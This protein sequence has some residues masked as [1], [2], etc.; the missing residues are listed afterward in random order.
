MVAAA[1]LGVLLGSTPLAWA[2]GGAGLTAPCQ[3]KNSGSGAIALRGAIAVEVQNGTLPG[4]TDVDYTVRL[5][6][7]GVTKFLRFTLNAEVFALSNEE[8]VCLLLDDPT[9]T[10]TVRDEFGLGN[11]FL[12]ITDN[13]LKNAESKGPHQVIPGTTRASTLG[14]ITI[15]AVE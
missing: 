9:F 6:R 10:Q 5:E 11:R 1:T 13:S 14:D 2:G 12:K 7:G 3:V 4:P 8:V 15:H